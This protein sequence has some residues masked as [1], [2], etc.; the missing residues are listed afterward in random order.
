LTGSKVQL[1]TLAAAGVLMTLL[2]LT[3]GL[4]TGGGDSV[5]AKQL[6]RGSVVVAPDKP[7]VLNRP[8]VVKT[9]NDLLGHITEAAVASSGTAA[10][11]LTNACKDPGSIAHDYRKC[12][13]TGP[14]TN[15]YVHYGTA[16]DCDTNPD[17]D[18]CPTA[19]NKEQGPTLGS[20]HTGYDRCRGQHGNGRVGYEL[21][22]CESHGYGGGVASYLRIA[23][24]SAIAIS[25]C[26]IG[27]AW[28]C[29]R[30]K[31]ERPRQ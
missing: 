27:G 24:S 17:P 9:V 7:A 13:S 26:V 5:S 12:G 30:R 29:R 1:G 16:G 23:G 21:G 20:T 6:P 22:G 4:L 14:S 18:A 19:P 2:V 28:L 11:P 15:A 3:I 25:A 31:A 10:G 8:V